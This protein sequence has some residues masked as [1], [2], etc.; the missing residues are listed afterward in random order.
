MKPKR[1]R[2]QP[3]PIKVDL[4]EFEKMLDD[5]ETSDSMHSL[6]SDFLDLKPEDDS[7]D[8]NSGDVE[9]YESIIM[10]ALANG[11]AEKYGF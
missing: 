1:K 4:S 10:N 7:D 8:W 11:D 5:A 9:D 2:I 6:E 3:V